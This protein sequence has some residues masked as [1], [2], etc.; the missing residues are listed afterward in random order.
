MSPFGDLMRN[1]RKAQRFSQLDLSLEADVSARHISFLETGKSNPSRNLVLTMAKVLQAPHKETNLLLNAAGFASVYS[2]FDWHSAEMGPIQKALKYQLRSHMPYP[3]VVIDGL[4]NLLMVNE[5]HEQIEGLVRQLKPDFPDTK[6]LVLQLFDANGYKD[7]LSNWQEVAC[8]LLRRLYQESVLYQDRKEIPQL[9]ERLLSYPDVPPDWREFLPMANAS[10]VI[11][12]EFDIM[13]V[14]ISLFS[15]IAT[16][17]TAVD[18]NL[19]DIRIESYFPADEASEMFL[20]NM[21]SQPTSL[22]ES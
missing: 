22:A 9:I 2:Q 7:F 19:Q 3:A 1:Y 21:T 18:V 6:N 4:W 16:F 13:G 20:Q 15:S 5:A 14:E 17:G 10:P 8:F 12:L 11:A